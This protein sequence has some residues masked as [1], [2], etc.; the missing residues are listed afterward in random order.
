MRS[1]KR[2]TATHFE[3]IRGYLGNFDKKNV[4]ALRRVLVEGTRQKDIAEE[5]GLSK[6]AVSAMVGR[7]WKIYLRYGVKRDGWKTVEVTLP[8]E[9]ADV[10]E[11]LANTL[12]TRIRK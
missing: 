4:D 6:E 9:Y 3:S 5:L 8:V 11:E 1:K 12:Q 10:I 7:C 2:L